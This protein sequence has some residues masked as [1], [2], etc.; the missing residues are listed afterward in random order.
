M[1]VVY[2]MIMYKITF[3]SYRCI[4]LHGVVV[5]EVSIFFLLFFIITLFPGGLLPTFPIISIPLP[6]PSLLPSPSPSPLPP[7]SLRGE[8]EEGVV[9]A[10]VLI[11]HHPAKWDNEE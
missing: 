10:V 3:P 4:H 2:I 6:S 11:P 8:E 9:G 7:S 5:F 1:N